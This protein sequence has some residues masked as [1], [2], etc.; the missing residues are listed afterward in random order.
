M[1]KFTPTEVLTGKIDNHLQIL[2]AVRIPWKNKHLTYN[3]PY[4][5]RELTEY[6][7]QMSSNIISTTSLPHPASSDS[8][9]QSTW[10]SHRH[11][12]GV[13][14]PSHSNSPLSQSTETESTH[15]LPYH[16]G[17]IGTYSN[18]KWRWNIGYQT[19]NMKC[20]TIA[21]PPL[22]SFN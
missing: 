4:S 8:S 1:C 17:S 16:P 5:M 6:P 14:S 21:I 22:H 9:K 20:I 10:P 11:C 3:I 12:P 19:D 7:Y 18:L 2:G 13:H 15:F